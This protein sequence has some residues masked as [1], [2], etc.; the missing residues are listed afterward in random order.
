MDDSDREFSQPGTLRDGTPL[1]IR[2]MRPDDR[3][4]IVAAFGKLDANTVYTRF[5]G[6]R[7]EI[8]AAT[9]D[10][11]AAIDFVKLAGIVATIGSGADETVIASATYVGI[12]TSDGA[13]AAEVAFTVEEDYQRQGLASRLLAAL[14]VLARRHGIA[15]FEAEVLTGNAAMLSVFQRSGLPMRRGRSE[16]GSVHVTLDLATPA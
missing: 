6:P 7:K 14:A 1:T 8:P 13:R 12:P 3:D 5:F 11:I 10:R 2:V 16:G 15:R 9:L 4:R